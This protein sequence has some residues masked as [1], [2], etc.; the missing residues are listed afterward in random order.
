[1]KDEATHLLLDSRECMAHG[2]TCDGCFRVAFRVHVS[3]RNTWDRGLTSRL[4]VQVY[5]GHVLTRWRWA[6]RRQADLR[7]T[8]NLSKGAIGGFWRTLM[9]RPMS[10][11]P[12]QLKK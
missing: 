3:H 5:W 11:V 12:R 7:W 8:D 6:T 1:M 9:T 10:S 2:A 4:G